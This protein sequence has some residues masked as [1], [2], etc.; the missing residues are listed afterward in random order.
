MGDGQASSAQNKK[1]TSELDGHSG[2]KIN[3][4]ETHSQGVLNN[5]R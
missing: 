2:E 1:V 4:T 5:S 3:P